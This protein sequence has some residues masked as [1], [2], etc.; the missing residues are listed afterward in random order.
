MSSPE[1]RSPLPSSQPTPV[2]PPPAGSAPH[3]RLAAWVELR[4]Q[5][6]ELNARLETMRLMLRL[7]QRKP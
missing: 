5:L 3:L 2:P 6:A 1:P 4:D 7:Q